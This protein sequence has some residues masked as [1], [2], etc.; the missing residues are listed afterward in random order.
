MGERGQAA[1]YRRGVLPGRG[2]GKAQAVGCGNLAQNGRDVGL[3]AGAGKPGGDG[4]LRENRRLS[5]RNAGKRAAFGA[6]G[7]A[8]F[9]AAVGPGRGGKARAVHG[10]AGC[11][12]GA[13]QQEQWLR[14]SGGVCRVSRHRQPQ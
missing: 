10:R 1:V 9:G 11:G 13:A 5:G 14:L 3:F 8:F 2:G 4:A 6:A 7:R 12:G